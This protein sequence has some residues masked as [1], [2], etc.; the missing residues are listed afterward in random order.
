MPA[1]SMAISS[2]VSPSTRTWSLPMD[3]IT[4]TQGVTMLVESRRPPKPVSNAA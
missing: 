3:V 1:F 2:K 4:D